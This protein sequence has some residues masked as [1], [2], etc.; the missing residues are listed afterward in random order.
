M[1]QRDALSIPLAG[2]AAEERT[3]LNQDT[4]QD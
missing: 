4:I 2:Q 3:G 1:G